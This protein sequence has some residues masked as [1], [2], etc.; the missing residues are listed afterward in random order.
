MEDLPIGFSFR[1]CVFVCCARSI[2]V[3]MFDLFS[4]LMRKCTS[5]TKQTDRFCHRFHH[6]RH[7]GSSL[8]IERLRSFSMPCAVLCCAVLSVFVLRLIC[9]IGDACRVR[10]SFYYSHSLF[11]NFSHIC[12]LAFAAY[13]ICVWIL[14]SVSVHTCTRAHCVLYAIHLLL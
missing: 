12:V 6:T 1:V 9:E 7:A 10:V 5:K 4:F 11:Y 8:A 2:T 13:G 3:H 14:I